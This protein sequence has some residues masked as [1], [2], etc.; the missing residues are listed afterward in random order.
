MKY[1][2]QLPQSQQDIIVKALR[3]Y[4]EFINTLNYEEI[5]TGLQHL[6]FDVTTL[7]AIF[8]DDTVDIKY[9]LEEEVFKNF[10]FRNGVDFPIYI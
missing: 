2:G 7:I 8:K 1:T 5:G 9:E 6:N 3:V 4:Q 10:V